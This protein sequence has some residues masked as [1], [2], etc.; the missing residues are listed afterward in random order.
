MNDIKKVQEM[1][2]SLLNKFIEICE[3]NDLRYYFTGGALIGVLRYQGFIPWDD[4][5]DIGMPRNDFDR[6]LNI[7]KRNMPN[8]YGICDRYTDQNWHFDMC[9]FV[10]LNTEIIIHMAEEPRKAHV[11]IDIFPLDGLP[12]NPVRRWI[13]MKHILLCRYVVQLANINTQVDVNRDRPFYEKIILWS[14]SS[15]HLNKW[16]HTD[17]WLDK[18][19]LILKKNNYDDSEFVGNLLGRYREKEVVPKRY[20]GTP[21]KGMFEGIT[22]RIPE[23]SHELQTALYGNYMEPPPKEERVAHNVTVVRCRK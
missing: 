1:V 8:G 14:A 5:I 17:K 20:F 15:L 23:C 3:K 10:D 2:L 19:E 12:S 13:R 7:V 22:V 4:D 18:L 11:W 9:Q 16:I 21:V 6:F